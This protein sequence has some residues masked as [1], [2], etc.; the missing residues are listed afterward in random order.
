M[1]NLLG[2]DAL[3]LDTVAG[4]KLV[5]VRVFLVNVIGKRL[6]A[7]VDFHAH[8]NLGAIARRTVVFNV[9][10]VWVDE[11][12]PE[13]P[14]VAAVRHLQDE[15]F[16]VAGHGFDKHPLGIEPSHLAVHGADAKFA[17]R[18]ERILED[19]IRGLV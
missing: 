5:V 14:R 1:D 19:A 2:R 15:A 16:A 12:K 7:L 9:N 10:A 6:A 17:P 18:L 8:A 3:A 11:L 4:R 13:P